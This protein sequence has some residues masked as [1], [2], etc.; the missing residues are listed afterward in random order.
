MTGPT[1]ALIGVS[2]RN[3]SLA[4]REALALAPDAVPQHLARLRSIDGVR[5]V[6][7]LATCNRTE[8][9]LVADDEAAIQRASEL[10][11]QGFSPAGVD[12]HYTLS[13]PA[14]A[15]HLLR[16]ACGLDSAILGDGQILGQVRQAYATARASQSTGAWLNRLFETA[17]RAGKRARYET[18]LGRGATTTASAAVDMVARMTGSL[19]QRQVLIVG[20]GETAKLAARHLARLRPAR[21]IIA[22]RTIES[23][24]EIASRLG[25]TAI[26]LTELSAALAG[27]DVVVSATSRPGAVISADLLRHVMAAR[28]GRP[29]LAVDLAVPRDIEEQAGAVA[30]V[31]LVGLDR[32]QADASRNLAARTAS[33]PQVQTIVADEGL[34]FETWRRGMGA[35]DV[36]RA[37][38]AHVEAARLHAL[39]RANLPDIDGEP[40]DRQTR[41]LMNRLLHHTM[42]RLKSL[43]GTAEGEA[44]LSQWRARYLD[45]PGTVKGL[46]HL[47]VPGTSKYDRPRVALRM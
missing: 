26:G 14:A 23:A 24:E 47:T 21:L 28:P 10:W 37:L 2:H 17:L 7:L 32:V 42:V 19:D 43:A 15:E 1:L 9:Y 25:A 4:R 6:A 31:T 38:R 20:A 33:I 45:V 8:V 46:T 11:R 3:A 30:G 36:I 22:N 41:L 18:V 16:V 13:G 44:R 35:A 12:E 5:E 34:A 40:L 39:E 27:A 29:L